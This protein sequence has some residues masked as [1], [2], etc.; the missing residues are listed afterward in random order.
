LGL[1]SFFKP[2]QAQPLSL[3]VS[4]FDKNGSIDPIFAFTKDGREYPFALRQDII[5]QINSLKKEF[6]FYKDYADKTVP[7]IFGETALEKAHKLNFYEAHSSLLINDGNGGFKLQPLPVQA[8]YAPVFA[9]EAMDINGD[10]LTDIILGG[11]LFGVKP[12]VGR[13]DALRGLVLENQGHGVFNAM[14]SMRSG[15]RIE[16]EVRHIGA[17]ENRSEKTIAFVRNNNTVLFYR[18]S[19]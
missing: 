7:E 4:D 9:I 17:F 13:Y 15:L 8:Q 19:D 18:R 6:V 11:N 14:S 1:N 10:N 2:S 16:G 12:Q 5:K 3:Y